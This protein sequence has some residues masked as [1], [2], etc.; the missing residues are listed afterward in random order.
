[1]LEY[2][3]K[4]LLLNILM[5]S[6]GFRVNCVLPGFTDTPLL[7]GVTNEA[8]EVVDMCVKMTPL[9]RMGRPEGKFSLNDFAY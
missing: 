8:K 6:N 1:M 9:K 7:H 4:D 2:D 3:T 5:R